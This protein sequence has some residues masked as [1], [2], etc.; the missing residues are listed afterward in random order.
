VFTA[1]K[2]DTPRKGEVALPEKSFTQLNDMAD[3]L[4]ASAPVEAPAEQLAA[5]PAVVEDNLAPVAAPTISP[6]KTPSYETV[7]TPLPI[8]KTS[9]KTSPVSGEPQ[10]SSIE[11]Q[12]LSDVMDEGAKANTPEPVAE[13]A[14]KK[15]PKPDAM[16]QSKTA[17]GGANANP[18]VIVNYD[19]LGH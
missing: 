10:S 12:T 7:P 15:E 19:V 14:E 2:P 5:T 16:V 8:N 18:S 1:P 3:P 9:K 4:L 6:P 11:I 17:P 13:K